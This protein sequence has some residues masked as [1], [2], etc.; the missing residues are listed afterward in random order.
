MTGHRCPTCAADAV[1]SERDARRWAEAVCVDLARIGIRLG[2]RVKVDLV[3]PDSLQ[4]TAGG[5]H[6]FVGGSTRRRYTP[7]G[8]TEATGITI[9][10]GLTGIHFGSTLAH[11][12][13]HCWLT[14]QGIDGL[15]APIEEGVCQVFAGAWLKKQDGRLAGALRDALDSPDEVYGV[16]YRLVRTAIRERGINAVLTCLRERRRLMCL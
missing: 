14:E 10:R 6:G 16:G 7:F 5:A 4:R 12:I 2:H 13:G 15:A 3:C 11:E 8:G 1:E 9:A